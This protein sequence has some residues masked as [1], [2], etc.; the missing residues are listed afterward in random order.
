VPEA[1]TD[2]YDYSTYTPVYNTG[3]EKIRSISAKESNYFNILQSLAETFEAWLLLRVERD[4]FGAVERKIISFKKYAGG[5]NHAGF[6]YGVNLKDIQRTFASKDIVTK[7]IVKP[8]N[9][10][11]GEDGFCTIARAGMNPSGENN[12]YDFQYYFRSNLLDEAKYNDVLYDPTGVTG[13]NGYFPRLKG[14]NEYM[15]YWNKNLLTNY[16]DLTQYKAKLAV[17][18][19]GAQAAISGIEEVR[20]RFRRQ[21]GVEIER[22]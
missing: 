20:E 8:N 4:D 19:A 5:D 15:T 6:K 11:Y 18:E 17:A 21:F 22:Y 9:N 10:E 13:L 12:I 16:S 1:I 14:L 2:E 7:L 3:A